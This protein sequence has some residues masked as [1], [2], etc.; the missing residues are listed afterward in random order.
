MSREALQNAALVLLDRQR[1]TAESLL[2]LHSSA[3][4]TE[5]STE[6]VKQD[7]PGQRKAA[8]QHELQ[9]PSIHP[10][11]HRPARTGFNHAI[12]PVYADACKAFFF[13]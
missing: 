6:K 2:Q 8:G 12:H 13:F 10:P 5:P 11:H 7:K 1:R 4:K 9:Y 3:K